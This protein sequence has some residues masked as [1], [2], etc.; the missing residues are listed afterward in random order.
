[1][2]MTVETKVSVGEFLT[3]MADKSGLKI[4]DQGPENVT[5]LFDMGEGRSQRVWV[6]ALGTDAGD[7]LIVG[8]FSPVLQVPQGEMI[9]QKAANELLRENATLAHGAWAIQKTKDGEYLVAFDTQIAQTMD[10]KEFEASV[11]AMAAVA[12]LKEKDLGHDLF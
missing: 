8:F 4:E 2:T 7:N 1:M 5:V 9:G 12:D 3:Q 10:P 11:R 6:R